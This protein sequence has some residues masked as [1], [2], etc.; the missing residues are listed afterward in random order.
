MV[1]SASQWSRRDLGIFVGMVALL[2]VSIQHGFGIPVGMLLLCVAPFV[3][4]RDKWDGEVSAYSVMNSDGRRIAGTF[5]AEQF[6]AQLRGGP[7]PELNSSTAAAMPPSAP[8]QQA[9]APAAVDPAVRRRRALEAAE[10]R[11]RESAQTSS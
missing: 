4:G 11:A 5:T 7:A 6:D 2:I 9:P 3:F 10:R 8:A 1:K